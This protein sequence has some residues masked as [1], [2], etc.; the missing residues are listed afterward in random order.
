MPTVDPT[1]AATETIQAALRAYS[2][3]ERGLLGI[4][5]L[6]R[7]IDDPVLDALSP[8]PPRPAGRLAPIH[9]APPVVQLHPNRRHGHATTAI[10]RPDGHVSGLAI[11]LHRASPIRDWRIAQ[12]D[13]VARPLLVD[14]PPPGW[15]DHLPTDLTDLIA[16]AQTARDHAAHRL[17]TIQRQL[18]QQD[19]PRVAA[20]LRGDARHARHHLELATRELAALRDVH[21]TRQRR[22]NRHAPYHTPTPPGWQHHPDDTDVGLS[23]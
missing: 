18:D 23:L 20:Q 14:N 19:D 7:W 2:L 4:A 6:R 10:Q 11:Q 1:A 17:T 5:A 15:R 12:L 9:I 16:A 22:R 21:R 8:L 13:D 3:A